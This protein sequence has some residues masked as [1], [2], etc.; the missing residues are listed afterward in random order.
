[1]I[2]TL[3]EATPFLAGGFATNLLIAALSMAF[4]TLLGLLLAGMRAAG[5]WWT[6]LPAEFATSL[7]R[8][9]PSFV[10]LFYVAFMLPVE[11][12]IGEQLIAIPLW[13]KATVALTIPVVG[14][15]SDQAL[16]LRQQ[17]SEGDS[18]ALATFFLAWMQYFLIIIMASATASVIGADEIVGR[19]NRLIAQDHRPV[20][21]LLTY[22][23]VSLWFLAA[24]LLFSWGLRRFTAARR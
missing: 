15:V 6:R 2:A 8:N 16:G 4:G 19:A 3:I 21:L 14:F 23:Y 18:A 20:F 9:V 12:A 1:M 22:I 5:R 17:R 11:V 7:C 10:L 24:G 13:I